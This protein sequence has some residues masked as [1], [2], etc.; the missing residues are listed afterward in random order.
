MYIDNKKNCDE[1]EFREK[2]TQGNNVQILN[3]INFCLFKSK[4]FSRYKFFLLKTIFLLV[5][6]DTGFGDNK[7]NCSDILKSVNFFFKKRILVVLKMFTLF[8]SVNIE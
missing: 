5:C 1:R 6:I 4:H 3:T 7:K 8:P 2:Y